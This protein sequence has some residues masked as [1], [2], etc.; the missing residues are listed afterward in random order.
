MIK[1]S[2]KFFKFMI[3]AC[4]TVTLFLMEATSVGEI[5]LKNHSSG[6][7]IFDMMFSYNSDYVYSA[8]GTLGVRGI[9]HYIR[10]LFVDFIFIIS[11]CYVQYNLTR[12]I[13]KSKEK[14]KIIFIFTFLR[15][16][17]D[18]IENLFLLIILL[19]YPAHI[20]SLVFLSSKFTSIKFIVL[21]LW[22][23]S[24]INDDV[25][26]FISKEK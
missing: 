19:N 1:N 7:E 10:L 24:I 12:V 23:M 2:T 25:F 26:K 18:I 3:Y 9:Q 11:F 17:C 14:Y 13:I 5:G 15:A 8:L 21:G 22:I 20:D 6:F 16:A 4:F